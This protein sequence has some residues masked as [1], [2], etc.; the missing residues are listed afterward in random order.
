MGANLTKRMSRANLKPQQKKG[1]ESTRLALGCAGGNTKKRS[2]DGVGGAQTTEEVD[3]G[4]QRAYK[5]R[6]EEQET[7][8]EGNQ[9]RWELSG[10]D[11]AGFLE[12]GR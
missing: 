9:D 6:R 12:K 5:K 3:H 4:G 10:T 7:S 8:R 11:R 2:I 1:W